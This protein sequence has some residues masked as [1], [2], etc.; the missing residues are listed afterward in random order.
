MSTTARPE[1]A[2]RLR[3]REVLDRLPDAVVALDEKL[4]VTVANRMA[5]RVFGQAVVEGEPLAET[6]NHFAIRSFARALFVEA[7]P[8][9]EA[10]VETRHATYHLRGLPQDGTE[11]ALVIVEDASTRER[12]TRA[13]REFV[14]N[15][16][17]EI[18]NPLTAISTAIEVLQAGAKESQPERDVFLDHIERECSRLKR[19]SNA[20]LVLARAQ[21]GERVRSEVVEVLPILKQIAAALR[22]AEGVVVRVDCR[23]GVAVVVSPDLLAQALENLATNAAAHTSEGEIVLA[24][25]TIDNRYVVLEV[26]DTGSG[27]SDEEQPRVAERFYRTGSKPGFGLGLAIASEAFDVLGG[28]LTLESREPKGTRAGVTLPLAALVRR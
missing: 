24:A 12:K 15:A 2:E 10:R 16:A 6:W 1:A 19:L 28:R 14:A 5:R 8:E 18:R 23:P 7:A 25:R 3:L 22:P 9:A 20:L 27:I 21:V 13:E 11:N 17:H 26:T 4:V